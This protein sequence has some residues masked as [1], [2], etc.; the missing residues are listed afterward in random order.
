MIPSYLQHFS[1]IA[2]L[3]VAFTLQSNAIHMHE[4]TALLSQQVSRLSILWM[5]YSCYLA[6]RI[7]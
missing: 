6:M 3:R 2:V 1:C 5:N 7:N 4:C